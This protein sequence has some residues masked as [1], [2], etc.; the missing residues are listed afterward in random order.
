V[1]AFNSRSG[2]EDGDVLRRGREGDKNGEDEFDRE[3]TTGDAGLPRSTPASGSRL[4]GDR[5][6]RNKPLEERFE[7]AV[8]LA[9]LRATARPFA[10]AT[11]AR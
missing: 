1:T 4:Q 6:D 5:R 7:A 3:E 2:S 10:S 8:K 11:A 9:A